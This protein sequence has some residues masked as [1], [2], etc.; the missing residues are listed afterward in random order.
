MATLENILNEVFV[1]CFLSEENN[2]AIKDI[3]EVLRT[4]TKS[5]G[6]QLPNY[7]KF[8]HGITGSGRVFSG[9][10]I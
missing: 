4:F 2:I 3:V 9:S 10:G 5:K 8:L 6:L 7:M 1:R